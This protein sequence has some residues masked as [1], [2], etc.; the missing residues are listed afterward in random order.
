L[1]NVRLVCVSG[2]GYPLRRHRHLRRGHVAQFEKARE[3]PAIARRK[4]NA[5]S[6]KV[7]SLGKR[8]ELHDIGKIRSGSFEHA[9]RCVAGIDF[10]VALIAEHEKPE[11]AREPD[12][13]G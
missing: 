2:N 4:T 8:L 13:A 7:R 11:S 3:E 1:R 6:R 9:G 12:D 5:Q 10:G